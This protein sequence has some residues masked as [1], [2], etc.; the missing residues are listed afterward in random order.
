MTHVS[1]F[2]GIDYLS[3]IKYY[4]NMKNIYVC[5]QCGKQFKSYNPNPQFC[6][7]KC[8]GESLQHSWI[9]FN[10]AKLLYEKGLTQ[11]EVALVLKTT[12][13]A[14]FALFKR[15]KYKCRVAK[16]RNQNGPNNDYWK[17]IKAGYQG[18][19]ARLYRE[20]GPAK[21]YKCSYCNRQAKDWANLTGKYE[22][23]NEYVPMC[24][25]CHRKY[26][27]ERRIKNARE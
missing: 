9:D 25:K 23:I 8:K 21:K 4:R 1:L 15:Q 5:K 14:I 13:K 18:F 26:D 16:K 20:K 24:R 6:S 7:N 17:G 27:S 3:G 11:R 10:E 19:H 12:Q 22:N 2:A